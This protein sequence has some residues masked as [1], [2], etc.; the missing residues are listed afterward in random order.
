MDGI[1]GIGLAEMIIIA[2]VLFIIGGPENATK[3]ARE[4]G[5]TVRKVREAWSR[6]VS[7]FEEDLGPEG[8]ELMDAT[9]ELGKDFQD[10][11]RVSSPRGLMAETSRYAKKSVSDLKADIEK[12]IAG[13]DQPQSAPTTDT[14]EADA[15]ESPADPRQYSA[16]QPP[17]H[18]AEQ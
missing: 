12:D 14:D 10:I 15:D 5:R 1:F 13:D 8:K 11:R 2:L 17:E 4:L 7:E 16:W 9:R 3:W 6:M 18:D